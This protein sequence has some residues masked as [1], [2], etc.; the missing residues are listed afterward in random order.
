MSI[1]IERWV[2]S[3]YQQSTVW[4][5][6][7]TGQ[8]LLQ[9]VFY[10]LYYFD[11]DLCHGKYDNSLIDYA[12][13]GTVLY[14]AVRS[15]TPQ[16]LRTQHLGYITLHEQPKI[17]IGYWPSRQE[18]VGYLFVDDMTDH[19]KFEGTQ[20]HTRI[21]AKGWEIGLLCS[22]VPG[23]G[24][25]LLQHCIAD[26]QQSDADFLRLECV[27]DLISYYRQFGFVLGGRTMLQLQLELTAQ[28]ATLKKPFSPYLI[29]QLRQALQRPLLSENEYVNMYHVK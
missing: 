20:S 8:R 23:T 9:D 3:H 22:K 5:N 25:L 4:F 16:Q 7:L 28:W 19:F 24:A 6:P 12:M 27:L 1:T 26:W 14:M 18:I 17:N 29:Q 21:T 13:T 15:F 11:E 10:Q 2:K